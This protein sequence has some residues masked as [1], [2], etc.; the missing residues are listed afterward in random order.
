MVGECTQGRQRSRESG[1]LFCS[2]D[3]FIGENKT[4][5]SVVILQEWH[6]AGA[7]GKMQGPTM[8]QKRFLVT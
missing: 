5:Q 2:I 8:L 6:E 4:K 3:N 7:E 1:L